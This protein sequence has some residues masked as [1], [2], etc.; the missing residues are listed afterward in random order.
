MSLHSFLDPPTSNLAR[1]AGATSF[2]HANSRFLTAKGRVY[3][4]ELAVGDLLLT[5]DDQTHPIAAIERLS[6]RALSEL[7]GGLQ[8]IRIGSGALGCGLPRRETV[9]ATD[10][11]LMLS[12]RIAERM[13]GAR[14][15]LVRAG[16]LCQLEGVDLA[17]D[18]QELRYLRIL[19]PRE[20]IALVNGAPLQV[21][22]VPG[23]GEAASPF[24][25]PPD[26][27]ASKLIQRHVR[28]R[29]PVVMRG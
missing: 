29:V 11:R 7:T 23:G 21:L 27:R 22:A 18:L 9:V 20:L 26:R 2:V 3:A 25:I 16:Q 4:D 10:Q 24:A 6:F 13:F 14:H 1:G 5:R 19:M 28:N 12:S 17:F 15:V 8:P